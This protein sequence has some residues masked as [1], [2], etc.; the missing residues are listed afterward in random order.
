MSRRHIPLTVKADALALVAA[1]QPSREVAVAVGVDKATV[2]RW[3]QGVLRPSGPSQNRAAGRP[4][5]CTHARIEARRGAYHCFD[6]GEAILPPPPSLSDI[7]PEWAREPRLNYRR[8]EVV[9][10]HQPS[11][12]I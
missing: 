3:A 11:W 10:I 9:H 4:G 2:N 8:P 12:R 5:P 6:C 7:P 1:G